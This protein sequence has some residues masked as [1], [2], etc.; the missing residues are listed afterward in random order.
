MTLT[1]APTVS[2]F[3]QTKPGAA[4]GSTRGSSG[5]GA[6]AIGAA[7]LDCT[8]LTNALASAISSL[9]GIAEVPVTQSKETCLDSIGFAL[10]KTLLASITD[11]TINWINDGFEGRPSF[12][13]DSSR[14]F[15]EQIKNEFQLGL[16]ELKQS[17]TIYFDLIKQKVIYDQRVKLGSAFT[18]DK[19]IVKALCTY[20]NYETE[21]FCSQQLDADSRAELTNAYLSGQ[22]AGREVGWDWD[23]WN[24]M[25]Q[26]CGNNPFCAVTAEINELNARSQERITNLNTELNQ[27]GGFLGKKRCIEPKNF[28]AQLEEYNDAVSQNPENTNP[29]SPGY[30]AL[31][32]GTLPDRPVCAEYKVLTPGGV[33]ASKLNLSLGTSDRQLELADELNES[34]GAIFDA[35]LNKLLEDGLSSF[36]GDDDDGNDP[37]YSLDLKN[38]GFDYKPTAASITDDP[39]GCEALGGIFDE[40]LE[41]CVLP[42]NDDEASYPEFPWTFDVDTLIVLVPVIIED[43][44]DLSSFLT[45][46]PGICIEINGTRVVEGAEPCITGTSESGGNGENTGSG[47]GGQGTATLTPSSAQAGTSATITIV[48]GPANTDFEIVL[49]E[50][51]FITSSVTD[52]TGSATE[53]VILPQ[54]YTRASK[55]EIIFGD[56]SITLVRR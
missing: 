54:N 4:S 19:D 44:N 56:G 5:P 11:S 53:Q 46:N 9:F 36:N 8:G 42:E 10:A 30:N 18:L 37:Y 45:E 25:T 15:K 7:V 3:A 33:I 47:T 39:L 23:I 12:I 52:T 38:A 22:I 26:N 32:A 28:E 6:G 40:E 14:F 50:T 29:L 48:R 16:E 41:T 17:G 21:E 55:I 51:D 20:E 1:C 49:N 13:G 2:T 31:Q 43:G 24:S 27:S 35:L 34:I